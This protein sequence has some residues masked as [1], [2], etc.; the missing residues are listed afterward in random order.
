MPTNWRKCLSMIG[1]LLLFRMVA[2]NTPIMWGL[3]APGG[4]VLVCNFM[5]CNTNSMPFSCSMVVC[6]DVTSAVTKIAFSAR[7]RRDSRSCRKCLMSR[8]YEGS[9]STRGCMKWV[10]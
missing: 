6:S 1:R 2:S 9:I 4:R 10:T 3:A 7:G 8:K 5:Y